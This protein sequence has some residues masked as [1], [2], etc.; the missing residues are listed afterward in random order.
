MKQLIKYFLLSGIFFGALLAPLVGADEQAKTPHQVVQQTTEEVLTIVKDAKSSYEKDPKQFNSRVTLVLDKVI[1]FDNFARGVMGSYASTQRYKALKTDAE[2]AA[3]NERIQRFSATFKQGLVDTYA[4]GLLNFNGQKIETL[5]P[6]KGDDAASGT[7]TV[8]QNIF[9]DSGKPY[10]IQ[11]SMR[12][13]K[14][15]EWKLHN[16]II[17]GIN[18]GLT[19]RGQF[20]ESADRN[21]GDLDKVIATWKVEP[22]GTS[23]VKSDAVNTEVNKPESVKGNITNKEAKK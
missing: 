2:R 13:D 15:G 8:M 17:E 23:S 14:T 7:M 11:Y 19:Y 9:N 22:Q 10:V 5:P 3:F 16:L 18:L 21:K 1:D 12:R 6:R 4:N 20:T